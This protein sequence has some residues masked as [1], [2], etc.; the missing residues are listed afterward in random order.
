MSGWFSPR[1][2]CWIAAITVA[3][4]NMVRQLDIEQH[5]AVDARDEFDEKREQDID[6]IE[7]E[8]PPRSDQAVG[9]GLDGDDGPTKP[10]LP[11]SKARC[12]G[13]VATVTGASFLNVRS[14]VIAV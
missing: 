5:P 4:V 1:D 6:V 2:L 11:F 8:N 14:I 9:G 13:L 10:A 3:A 12:I 7:T